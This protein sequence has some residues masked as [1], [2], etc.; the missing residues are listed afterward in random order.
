MDIGGIALAFYGLGAGV[1]AASVVALKRRL[2]LSK[3]KHASLSGHARVARR[4]A[5]LMPFYEYDERRFFCSDNA[6]AKIAALR[7]DGFMRLSALYASR[8]RQT[9]RQTAEV[10]DTI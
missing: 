8:F 3:A 7:R 9:A 4:V 5:S 10:V 1:A 2:A 6:P